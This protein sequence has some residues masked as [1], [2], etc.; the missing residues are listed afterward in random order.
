MRLIR[1][2]FLIQSQS[3]FYRFRMQYLIYDLASIVIMS[4]RTFSDIYDFG[5]LFC[6]FFQRLRCP[7]GCVCHNYDVYFSKC[8][9][10]RHR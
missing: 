9:L 7:L 6:G 5:K 4:K 1:Q 3:L 8:L 10:T 2:E